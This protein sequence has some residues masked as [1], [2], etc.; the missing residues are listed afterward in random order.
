M[1]SKFGGWAQNGHNKNIS[2]FEFGGLVKDHHT[3]MYICK[4]EIMTDFNL[5]VVKVDC[6]I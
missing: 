3:Y 6:Q 4:Y 1:G 5:A 2:G